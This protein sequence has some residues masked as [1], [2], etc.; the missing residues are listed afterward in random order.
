MKSKHIS[1]NPKIQFG[2]PCVK[3]TRIS[4]ATIYN[5]H[6]GGDS[7]KLLSGLFDLNFRQINAAIH[8]YKTYQNY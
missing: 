3:G 1:I 7:V 6:K 4:T 5:M 2:E 8:F